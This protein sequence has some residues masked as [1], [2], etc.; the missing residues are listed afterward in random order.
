MTYEH[1]NTQVMLALLLSRHFLFYPSRL[2][3][4]K[5]ITK[6]ALIPTC[7]TNKLVTTTCSKSYVSTFNI[8]AFVILW[9]CLPVCLYN[10]CRLICLYLCWKSLIHLSVCL[11]L[12]PSITWPAY[13]SFCVSA[14]LSC[15]CLCRYLSF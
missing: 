10:L 9:F 14:F 1:K 12:C 8:W 11:S 2:S 13:W 3:V 5:I 4:H 6:I 15:L 7:K